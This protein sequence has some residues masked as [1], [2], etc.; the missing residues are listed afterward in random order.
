MD[1]SLLRHRK[2]FNPVKKYVEHYQRGRSKLTAADNTDLLRYDV[3]I[4]KTDDSTAAVSERNDFTAENDQNLQSYKLKCCRIA[5]REAKEALRIMPR[6][7]EA[8]VLL[9][10]AKKRLHATLNV[11]QFPVATFTSHYNLTIRYW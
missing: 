9:K 1:Q 11:E 7:V 4:S 10:E 5:S 3:W 6:S 2:P 8:K